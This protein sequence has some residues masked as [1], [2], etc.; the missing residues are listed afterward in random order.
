M[1]TNEE[2][3]DIGYLDY[4]SFSISSAL[5]ANVPSDMYASSRFGYILVI[6]ESLFGALTFALFAAY[7]F[8]WSLR[9]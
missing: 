2:N 7:V 3:G 6:L 5:P 4:V 8:R 9:K 1:H